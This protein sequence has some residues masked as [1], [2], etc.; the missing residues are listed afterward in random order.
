[1]PSWEK[2]TS[3]IEDIISEKKDL[4]AGSSSCSN[5]VDR[6]VW[7]ALSGHG[8]ELT[9]CVLIAQRFLPHV[10]KLDCAF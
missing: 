10:C 5:S 2:R 6:S 1:M 9:L 4:E 8:T 7:Q 3:E